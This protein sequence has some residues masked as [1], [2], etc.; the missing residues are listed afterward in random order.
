MSKNDVIRRVSVEDIIAEYEK[1]RMDKIRAYPNMPAGLEIK[2]KAPILK[3]EEF[4]KIFCNAIEIAGWFF[5]N[6]GIIAISGI[7]ILDYDL[8]IEQIMK[9]RGKV[10]LDTTLYQAGAVYETL[11]GVPSEKIFSFVKNQIDYGS[12][13]LGILAGIGGAIA[14]SSLAVIATGINAAYV[15]A[16]LALGTATIVAGAAA[17]LVYGIGA[18][19]GLMLYKGAERAYGAARN[20]KKKVAK[21]LLVAMVGAVAFGGTYLVS[22]A[23]DCI[24]DVPVRVV[25][26]KIRSYT[27]SL[28]VHPLSADSAG[29]LPLFSSTV[30]SLPPTAGGTEPLYSSTTQLAAGQTAEP[31]T[32]NSS[33]VQSL[34]GETARPGVLGSST[35]SPATQEPIKQPGEEG[36]E[37][38]I[39]NTVPPLISKEIKINF[40]QNLPQNLSL[41]PSISPDGTKL[42]FGVSDLGVYTANSDGGNLRKIGYIRNFDN[43]FEWS[44]D[45]REIVFSQEAFCDS[46]KSSSE[47]CWNHYSGGKD[48]LAKFDEVFVTDPTRDADTTNLKRVTFA[49]KILRASYSPSWSPNGDK[50]VFNGRCTTPECYK[51]DWGFG[52]YEIYVVEVNNPL[53]ITNISNNPADDYYPRWSP[54]GSTI[55]YISKKDGKRYVYLMNPDG[56]NQR[57]ITNHLEGAGLYGMEW[58]PD[59]RYLILSIKEKDEKW[60]DLYL[61]N[62]RNGNL[63]NITNTPNIS[64]EYPTI[65]SNGKMVFLQRK[66]YKVNL[67]VA[68]INSFQ[69]QLTLQGY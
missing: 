11:V 7:E 17:G 32:L 41:Y 19:S 14:V 40:P 34:P 12:M 33:T 52:N 65:S 31:A 3:K 45:G 6:G 54:D 46:S 26:E 39:K 48:E 38:N 63:I 53:N 55:A 29:P 22:R 30:E 62:I 44:R 36:D 21:A 25:K 27:D 28:T 64:E 37:D 1:S 49:S 2:I 61:L 35:A 23:Y 16:S 4:S 67:S 9:R 51:S 10:N 56:S 18:S 13:P 57:N 20:H 8:R 24:K 58:L 59:S 60:M 42:F 47:F 68:D 69:N 15:G 66:D 5:E 43:H 50:I